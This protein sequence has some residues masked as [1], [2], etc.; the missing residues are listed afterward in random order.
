MKS[1]AKKIGIRC[2]RL[3]RLEHIASSVDS[4]AAYSRSQDLKD[5]VERNLQ[6]AIEA[7]VDMGEMIISR[8]GLREPKDTKDVFV[9]L[10][11]WGIVD[12]KSLDF[13]IP[14]AGARNILVHGYDTID[15]AVVYGILKK[16]LSD[17]RVYLEQVQRF[18][19]AEEES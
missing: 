11:E 15:D 19:D 12:A 7:C 5:I 1:I 16:H 13:L 17:F 18:A 2:E 4:F 14:M 6:I 10:A 3:S 8:K 9:V